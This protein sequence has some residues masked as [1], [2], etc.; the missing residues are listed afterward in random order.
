MKRTRPL[1]EAAMGRSA[2]VFS[3]HYDD[4][5]LGCGGTII[6]KRQADAP[7]TIVFMTDGRESHRAWMDGSE[8]AGLRSREGRSAAE[9]LGVCAR[10]VVELNFPET[11][12][13]EHV[14][15]AAG[16]VVTLLTQRRPDDVFLPYR[17]DP[18][19]DHRATTDAVR[20]ALKRA[21]HVAQVYEYPIWAWHRW[22][23]V[24]RGDAHRLNPRRW[25]RECVRY[26]SRLLRDLRIRVDVASALD[27]KRE[28]LA[29]HRS[30]TV[31]LMDSP[32][33]PILSDVAGGDFLRC[34]FDRTEVFAAGGA[35]GSCETART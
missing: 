26:N 9:V 31:R 13:T 32:T 10:D 30:Q 23:W 5:T 2:M 27:R 28:A 21:G 1:S 35:D 7:V 4:E 3:P 15:E 34:F 18:P 24:R 8:L 11:R 16:Q 22:P 33:W 19:A 14:S 12:L 17:F 29:R 6:R 25:F 20:E